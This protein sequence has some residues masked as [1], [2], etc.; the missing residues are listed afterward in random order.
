M[1]WVSEGYGK[2]LLLWLDSQETSKAGTE[3]QNFTVIVW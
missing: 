2:S 1:Q 3:I